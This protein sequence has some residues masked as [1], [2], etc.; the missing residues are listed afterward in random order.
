MK[1]LV[2]TLFLLGLAT[3]AVEASTVFDLRGNG[4]YERSFDFSK[5]G[6]NL[7]VISGR[8]NGSSVT[9]SSSD[10]LY[11]SN[12]NGLGMYSPGN[13][14]SRE[15]DGKNANE[16]IQF[17]FD[18]AVELVSITFGK[19]DS[20]DDFNFYFDNGAN[21]TERKDD[22]DIPNSGKYLFSDLWTGQLFGVGSDYYD[23]DFTIKKIEVA[24]ITA[25][26]LPA[27]LPLYG[28]G[29]ALI[30]FIGWRKRRKAATQA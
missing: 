12:G 21:F 23:D 14:K 28:T 8:Q 20:N 13:G 19:V 10:W 17:Y 29:L 26:P 5:D 3:T 9:S 4:S 6:I 2:T 1:V 11:Q 22:V 25:I 7:T 16:L 15:I 24:A 30:G 18:Q 27:A